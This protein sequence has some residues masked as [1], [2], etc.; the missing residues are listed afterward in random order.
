V[1]NDAHGANFSDI[2]RKQAGQSV[3]YKAG[4]TFEWWIDVHGLKNSFHRNDAVMAVQKVD[5]RQMRA[6]TGSIVDHN[7][8]LFV[9]RTLPAD[10]NKLRLVLT[11]NGVTK[12]YTLERQ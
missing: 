8:E 1:V 7:A 11:L 9:F 4:D 6:A 12:D 3:A 2:V 10:D 5:E